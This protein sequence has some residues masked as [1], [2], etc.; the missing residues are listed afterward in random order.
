MLAI[1]LS[2]FVGCCAIAIGYFHQYDYI[3]LCYR[4]RT[5][6]SINEFDTKICSFSETYHEARSKFRVAAKQLNAEQ[7]TFPVLEGYDGH[8]TIDIA[9]IKPDDISNEN[10]HGMVIHSSGTHGVE[11]YAGSAIQVQFM[12][13]LASLRS[14]G[15]TLKTK[16]VLIH[17]I[18]PYGMAHFR[19][20][21][22][23]NVDLNRNALN[24]K[25]IKNAKK[26]TPNLAHY[27]DFDSFFNPT[28]SPTWF[29]VFISMWIK[30]AYLLARHGRLALKTAI[31]SGQCIGIFYGGNELQKSHEIVSKFL[32]RFSDFKN[33]VTWIDVHTGLGPSGHST[34]LCSSKCMFSKSN[35]KFIFFFV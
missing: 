10:G 2:I 24:E 32:E 7:Y 13:N 20:F 25:E 26:R 34:L 15:T 5:Y 28:H 31:V 12:R 6:E 18:N 29:D 23:N 33:T 27:D 22:E 4:G 3:P 19:R 1:V 14:Q 11:G 9:V 35:F 8:Y 17:A 16:V 21:N 30:A